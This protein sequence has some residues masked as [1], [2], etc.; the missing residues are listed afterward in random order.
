M[1]EIPG[2]ENIIVGGNFN[3][4]V[5]KDRNGYERVHGGYGFGDRNEAGVSIL[6]F[7]VAYDRIVANT[8]FKKRD[9]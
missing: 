1:Q 6:D 8:F 7:A 9:K 3:G 5:G 2:G 4:H